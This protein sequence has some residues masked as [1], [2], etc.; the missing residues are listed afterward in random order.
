MVKILVDFFRI[1]E[2]LISALPSR[3]KYVTGYLDNF[4]K[5]R[6]IRIITFDHLFKIKSNIMKSKQ[7]ERC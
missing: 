1:Q 4:H 6:L 3:L 5:I 2:E 7:V